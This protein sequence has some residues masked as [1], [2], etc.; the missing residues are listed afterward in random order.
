MVIDTMVGMG[1]RIREEDRGLALLNSAFGYMGDGAGGDD[2]GR[3][4]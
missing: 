3:T 2:D 4:L 1:G